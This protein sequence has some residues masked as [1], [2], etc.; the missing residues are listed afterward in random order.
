MKQADMLDRIRL[1][2]EERKYIITTH[3]ILRMS[4]RGVTVRDLIGLIVNGEI[5]EEYPNREPCPAALMLGFISGKP[6]HAVVAICGCRLSIITVY[7][8]DEECWEDCRTR[9]S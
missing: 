4:E 1:L 5:I 7:W 2:V 6:C 8:P 9:R 3:A